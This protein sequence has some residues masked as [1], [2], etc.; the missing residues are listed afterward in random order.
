MNFYPNTVRDVDPQT[1]TCRMIDGTEMPV[2]EV[3]FVGEVSQ[4][5][6]IIQFHEFSNPEAAQLSARLA[7]NG[8]MT[9]RVASE[10]E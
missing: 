7:A 10:Q 5:S 9:V 3:G 8:G 6:P 1:G 2:S 4:G